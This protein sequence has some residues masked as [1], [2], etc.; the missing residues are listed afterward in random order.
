MLLIALSP[1]VLVWNATIA[2]ES[3]ATSL[4]VLVIALAFRV[5]RGRSRYDFTAL[6]VVL[7]AFACTR[8]T[9]SL[10]LLVIAAGAAVVALARAS[11][12]RRAVAMLLVCVLAAGANMALAAR[13][14]RWYHPLTETIAARILGS[15]AAT[16]YFVARGMPYDPAVRA[17]HTDFLT[18]VAD[19]DTGPQYAR[20]RAWIRDRGRATYVRFLAGHPDWLLKNPYDDRKRLLAP[21]LPYG[22]I[23]HNEPRGAFVVIGALAMPGNVV[24]VEIWMAAALVAALVIGRR[25]S[26]RPMVVA[27]GVVAALVVPAFLAAW[28]GDALEVDRHSLGAAVQLRIVLWVVALLALDRFVAR[29]RSST[30]AQEPIQEA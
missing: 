25:R 22:V 12:R 2:T 10:L 27:A 11:L 1:G 14:H 21:N 17:L 28:H 6:L 30:P 20:F 18:S 29:N 15:R 3:L 16:G 9:N 26:R 13:A 23:Y 8:D 24:L 7:V 4:L 5:A 19:L